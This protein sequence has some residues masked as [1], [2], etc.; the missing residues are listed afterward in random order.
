MHRQEHQLDGAIQDHPR[1]FAQVRHQETRH[2]SGSAK[3]CKWRCQRFRTETALLP[4]KELLVP[5][6]T[7]KSS[8]CS[9]QLGFLFGL[10]IMAA[11]LT[12]LRTFLLVQ[13]LY[14]ELVPLNAI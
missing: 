12:L 14:V 3:S 2:Q 7:R 13:N 4:G 10:S 8:P 5:R 6:S 1:D 9:P 11:L